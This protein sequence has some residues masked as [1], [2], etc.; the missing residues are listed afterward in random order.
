MAEPSGGERE[1]E[2]LSLDEGEEVVWSGGP[3]VLGSI[4][5]LPLVPFIAVWEYLRIVNTDY[6]ITTEAVYRRSGV[7]SRS[8][9][10]I[11]FDKIQNVSFSQGAFGTY[12]GYGTVAISTAG[13]S[14]TEMSFGYVENP[15]SVQERLSGQI[16][17]Q[18]GEGT[19][20]RIDTCPE[21]GHQLEEDW[22]ACP[23]CGEQ[24]RERCEFCD[25]L[26]Q[27]GWEFCP[28]CGTQRQ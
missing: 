17:Q 12:F 9:K 13:S 7:I 25:S 16:K 2:W 20:G 26:L 5:L 18:K 3:P 10:K 24:V 22:L 19:T 11:G 28:F 27:P 1:L 4:I 14:G 21:C 8:V 23:A 15:Q 6:V